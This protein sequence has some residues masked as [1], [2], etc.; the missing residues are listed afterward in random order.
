MNTVGVLLWFGANILHRRLFNVKIN[1]NG[2][3]TMGM[4]FSTGEVKNIIS[5][6]Y[7][8]HKIINEMLK[9]YFFYCRPELLTNKVWHHSIFICDLYGL[10]ICVHQS[11]CFKVDKPYID[12]CYSS[13]KPK[14]LHWNLEASDHHNITG[15][16]IR[17]FVPK[18]QAKKILYRSY[19]HFNEFDNVLKI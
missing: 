13:L 10:T 14:T 11:T 17:Q 12:R 4:E 7:K 16:A 6:I 2:F 3:E 15:A 8:Y 19:T 1:E 5:C 18:Q 9:G